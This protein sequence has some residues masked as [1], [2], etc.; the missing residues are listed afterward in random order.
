[1]NTFFSDAKIPML[2][3]D[4]E[5]L[6]GKKCDQEETLIT[7]PIEALAK[8]D[9]TDMTLNDA[10]CR[11]EKNQTHWILK[12]KSTSCDS[13]IS[14]NANNP[15]MRNEIHLKFS[16]QSELYGYLVRVRFTCKYAPGIFGLYPVTD[17]IS[18]DGLEYDR[19]VHN[20]FGGTNS[21]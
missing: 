8:F 2:E 16:P 12:T 21:H 18:D 1:M 15:I 11:A 13:V 20:L 6:I 3:K 14:F 5:A 4:L 17:D 19:Y 10:A 9:V 7:L